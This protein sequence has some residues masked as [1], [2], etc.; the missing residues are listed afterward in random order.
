[1]CSLTKKSFT[2]RGKENY[3]TSLETVMML[4][5]TVQSPLT[6]SANAAVLGN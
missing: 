5:G 2:V 4:V 1:M 3:S 6:L